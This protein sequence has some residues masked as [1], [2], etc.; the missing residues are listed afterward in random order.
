MDDPCPSLVRAALL[1]GF[2]AVFLRGKTN[3]ELLTLVP[4][5]EI[6][7]QMT[8]KVSETL[9]PTDNEQP[10][11][12]NVPLAKDSSRLEVN[13]LAAMNNKEL[14]DEEMREEP[15]K[16]D[17]KMAVINQNSTQPTQQLEMGTPSN[18]ESV[19]GDNKTMTDVSSEDKGREE[20]ATTLVDRPE[21]SLEETS[22]AMSNN[23]LN[24]FDSK[25]GQTDAT[26]ES[27]P[28]IPVGV[29]HSRMSQQAS[30]GALSEVVS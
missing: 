25:D 27:P 13:I 14:I 18:R 20:T 15:P 28:K 11:Q 7:T 3:T 4:G 24:R 16:N 17:G 23:A 26:N 12:L 1:K 2:S 22:V 5:A 30:A 6:K 21:L 9:N 19:G 29:N 10:P 8:E